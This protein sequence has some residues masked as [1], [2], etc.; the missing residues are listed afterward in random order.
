MDRHDFKYAWT[1]A[2]GLQGRI[3]K[4]TL[5]STVLLSQKW[6]RSSILDDSHGYVGAGDG[7]DCDC[8]AVQE[9]V[10]VFQLSY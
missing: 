2:G 6:L 1:K 4:Q 3:K 7:R 9:T 8:N 5:F 10:A